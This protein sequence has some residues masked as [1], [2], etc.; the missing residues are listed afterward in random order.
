[1]PSIAWYKNH[2]THW[3][4][5]GARRFRLFSPR[6]QMGCPTRDKQ[7][8]KKSKNRDNQKVFII[9]KS[10]LCILMKFV[11]QILSFRVALF[12]RPTTCINANLYC[13]KKTRHRFRPYFKILTAIVVTLK[14]LFLRASRASVIVV[15]LRLNIFIPFFCCQRLYCNKNENVAPNGFEN[16][17]CMVRIHVDRFKSGFVHW[18]VI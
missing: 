9:F 11:I 17:T 12:C 7:N 4:R 3:S 18:S 6:S 2:P 8:N 1:M 16:C 13:R 10:L 15:F 14:V 5:E